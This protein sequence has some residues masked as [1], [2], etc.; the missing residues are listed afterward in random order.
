MNT[1]ADV[2]LRQKWFITDHR[3]SL[4]GLTYNE[5]VDSGIDVTEH[6]IA[7]I[8]STQLEMGKLQYSTQYTLNVSVNFPTANTTLTIY[9]RLRGYDADS[10][11]LDINQ[12]VIPIREEEYRKPK[13]LDT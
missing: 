9:Y 5:V 1:T 10:F 8:S 12:M 4:L 13:I 6:S 11:L 7:N 3:L 2:P